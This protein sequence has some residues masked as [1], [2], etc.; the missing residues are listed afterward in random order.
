MG[1]GAKGRL[2]AP[3]DFH[4]DNYEKLLFTILVPSFQIFIQLNSSEGTYHLHIIISVQDYNAVHEVPL[5]RR[6][7]QLPVYGAVA[8]L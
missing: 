8:N 5:C 4:T 3:F 6:L 1:G 2:A 7:A